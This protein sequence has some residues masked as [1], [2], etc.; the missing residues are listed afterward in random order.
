MS[1]GL[2][3]KKKEFVPFPIEQIHFSEWF[4]YL[5]E[6]MESSYICYPS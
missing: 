4:P 3:F 6:E 5:G 1:L 2:F